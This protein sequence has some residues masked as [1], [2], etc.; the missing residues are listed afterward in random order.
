[1]TMAASHHEDASHSKSVAGIQNGL[2]ILCELH[3]RTILKCE[4]DN[5]DNRFL[6]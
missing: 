6:T 4:K 5:R 3:A 2:R 1:M